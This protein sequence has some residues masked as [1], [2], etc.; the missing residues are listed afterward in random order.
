MS[1]FDATTALVTGASKGIG[2]GIAER[3]GHEG[4][5]VVVHYGTDREGAEETVH[6]IEKEGGRAVAVGADLSSPKAAELLTAA[7]DTA[8]E[9]EGVASEIDILVHNAGVGSSSGVGEI[10]E[11]EYDRLFAVN[12]RAPL[13]ITQAL[14]PRL[15]D[16]GRIINISTGLT[17][18]TTPSMLPYGMSKGA[19]EVFTRGMAVEL[20]HRG[21]TVNAVAPG[22]VSVDRTERQMRENPGMQESVVGLT[23]LQRLG[24]PDDI[25]SVVAFLA[26]DDGRWITGQLVDATGG[27]RI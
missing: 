25:A 18:V 23:A 13:F 6:T 2:R 24:R 16:G 26:S 21:I 5:L 15:R 9:A 22:L 14:L 17:R 8:L 12:V 7:L 19:L 27:A 10:T 11:E 1:R 3:L 20:G 4:A